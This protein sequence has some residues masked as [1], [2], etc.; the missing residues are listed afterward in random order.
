MAPSPLVTLFFVGWVHILLY[1]F[2]AVLYIVGMYLLRQRKSRE[3]TTFLVVS[4][5]LLFALATV[6]AIV[7]TLVVVGGYLS[8]PL[9]GTSPTSINLLACSIIEFI[10]IHLVDWTAFTI[11][12]Y[13]CFHIWGRRFLVIVAPVLFFLGETVVYYSE[14]HQYITVRFALATGTPDQIRDFMTKTFPYT[15]TTVVLSAVSNALPP[16]LI[17][18]R[19]W[20][21][22]TRLQDI[23][24]EGIEGS[25]PQKYN[26]I[27][28]ITLESGMIIP[29]FLIIYA[30]FN[31]I[32]AKTGAHGDAIIVLSTM[33]PQIIALAPLI[34]MIRVALGLTA[35]RHNV[36]NPTSLSS[37]SFRARTSQGCESVPHA[38][39]V[40]RDV[41]V[42]V[43]VTSSS[44]LED[45]EQN[46]V[47]KRQA[48]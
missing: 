20:T 2:N 26:A 48:I 5:S 31:V 41:A 11:L 40:H 37:V 7:S 16:F 18:G 45:L 32:N 24:H 27:I 10:L 39:N 33:M 30:V 8:I 36:G 23:M 19:M 44:D 15:I 17:A 6:S 43:S 25:L 42:S 21:M 12:L 35:E 29:T 46:P 3:G 28:A 4:S 13:R 38:L 22:K 47:S 14:L 1:G 34:I 9:P